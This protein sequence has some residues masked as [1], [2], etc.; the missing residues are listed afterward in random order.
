MAP[1]QRLHIKSMHA[2]I[3]CID[4]HFGLAIFGKMPFAHICSKTAHSFTTEKRE[5]RRTRTRVGRCADIRDNTEKST[6]MRRS[7]SLSLTFA[8]AADADPH[9]M[10]SNHMPCHAPP[11]LGMLCHMSHGMPC[12]AMPPDGSL[13]TPHHQ[14]L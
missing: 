10:S 9:G 5:A 4:S 6:A 11:L 14:S 8:V 13:L 2:C 3:S 1:L 7:I 12:Y